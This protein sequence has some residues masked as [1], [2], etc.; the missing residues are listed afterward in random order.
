MIKFMYE[1]VSMFTFWFEIRGNYG[2]L[3]YPKSTISAPAMSIIKEILTDYL[4]ARE[5]NNNTSKIFNNESLSPE[6]QI[7]LLTIIIHKLEDADNDK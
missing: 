1:Q 7:D 5:I 6:E 2:E 3:L 4:F